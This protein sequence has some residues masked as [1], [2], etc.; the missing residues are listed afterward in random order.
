[1][2]GQHALIIDDTPDNVQVLRMLLEREGLTTSAALKSYDVPDAL[3]QLEQVDVIFLDLEMHNG[4][5][6]SLLNDLKANPR[7]YG[8]P[9]I[10][11]TVHIS[12]I[13]NA[14]KAGF[15]GFIA[16]PIKMTDFPAHLRRILDGQPVWVY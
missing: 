8:V 4:D 5:Y 6:Y 13:D 3:D 12:E 9:V 7:L 11:Y 15:D 14:R 2:L 16:K 1:M 10:A